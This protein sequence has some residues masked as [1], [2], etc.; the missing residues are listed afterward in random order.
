MSAREQ[1]RLAPV[2]R[3]P[4]VLRERVRVALGQVVQ[5]ADRGLVD[6]VRL[7]LR[8][9]VEYAQ[10]LDQRLLQDV[11]ANG[12]AEDAKEARAPERAEAVD[13]ERGARP[14]W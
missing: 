7:L 1:D 2:E 14:F 8:G 10:L 5:L 12:A 3:S 11:G 6:G 9:G 13:R 4:V